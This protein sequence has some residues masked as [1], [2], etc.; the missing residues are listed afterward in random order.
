MLANGLSYN[1]GSLQIF[2]APYGNPPRNLT[3]GERENS[4]WPAGGE[5]ARGQR[6]N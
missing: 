3:K 6:D 5:E 4:A 1:F 2:D